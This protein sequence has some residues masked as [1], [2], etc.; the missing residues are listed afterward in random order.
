MRARS[1]L[2]R[3]RLKVKFLLTALTVGVSLHTI[4]L[5]KGAGVRILS[6]N[7]PFL[8][9]TTSWVVKKPTLP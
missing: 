9:I 7:L 5:G 2:D 1:I 4:P 6:V 8:Y 3:P